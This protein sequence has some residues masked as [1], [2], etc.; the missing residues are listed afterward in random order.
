MSNQPETKMLSVEIPATM[1][2]ALVKFVGHFAHAMA[3]EL[4]AAE[5]NF[6]HHDVAL[7]L[8]NEVP[9]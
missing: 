2:P 4:H 1:D 5:K 6:S 7:A 3:K 9:A 8:E